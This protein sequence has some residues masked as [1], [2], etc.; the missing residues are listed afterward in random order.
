MGSF[1]VLVVEFGGLVYKLRVL[2]VQFAIGYILRFRVFVGLEMYSGVC[3]IVLFVFG[4]GPGTC[5]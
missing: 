2:G 5:S 4:K 3:G 1:S